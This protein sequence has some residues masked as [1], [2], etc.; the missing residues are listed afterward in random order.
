VGL[1]R[2][3]PSP[4]QLALTALQAENS[5]LR[6]QLRLER[7]QAADLQ[8]VL[9]DRLLALTNAPALR[10]VRRTPLGEVAPPSKPTVSRLPPYPPRLSGPPPSS[11]PKPD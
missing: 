1:F 3:G 8:Q 2:T 10:E 9:L 4:A 7:Q 11:P 6:A 5:D